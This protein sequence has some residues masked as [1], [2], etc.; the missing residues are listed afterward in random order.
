MGV[1]I[2]RGKQETLVDR[3]RKASQRQRTTT[4][5]KREIA[6]RT[7]TDC[8]DART[9]TRTGRSGDASGHRTRVGHAGHSRA[10]AE[11]SAF[12]PRDEVGA[13]IES[14]YHGS[15]SFDAASAA[16]GISGLAMFGV[17]FSSLVL[18]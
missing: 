12:A 13:E 18:G 5:K 3:R 8:P 15:R 9:R 1:L 14:T 7:R 11:G 6:M 4:P 2:Q 17:F 16:L 10:T